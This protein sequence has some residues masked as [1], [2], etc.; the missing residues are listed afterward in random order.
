MVANLVSNKQVFNSVFHVLKNPKKNPKDVTRVV[1]GGEKLK[2]WIQ[3]YVIASVHMGRYAEIY[4][5]PVKCLL[6]SITHR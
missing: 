3:P 6:V 2:L 4:N 1:K 5:L